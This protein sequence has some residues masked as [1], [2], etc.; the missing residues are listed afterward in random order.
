MANI[1]ITT[2]IYYTNDVP[3]IGHAYTT[4]A[5]DVLARFYRFR[6]DTVFFL[7]GSDEHGQ[8]IAR[9]AEEMG[10][11]PKEYVDSL[12]VVFKDLWEKLGISNDHFI[13]TTDEIHYA[14]CQAFFTK[15][16]AKGDIYKSRYAGLYCTGCESFKDE[17]ELVEGKCP[18]HNKAPEW[19]EEEDYF[20]KWSNYQQALEQ[21]FQDKPLFVLPKSRFNETVSFLG[22]GIKD[23]PISRTLISWGIPVP[24]DP[25]HVLY[26]WFDALINYLTGIGWNQPELSQR[27]QTF[28]EE[29]KVIHLMAKDILSKHA[30]LWPAML[31]SAGVPLP[32]TCFSHGYF[33][34]DGMKISKSIGNVID[35][36][37]LVESYGV[38][39]FRYFFFREFTFGEDG[40]YRE[41]RFE[42]RYNSDLAND[43]G[44]LVSR[45]T[46]MA[47][48]FLDGRVEQV[49]SQKFAPVIEALWKTWDEDLQNFRFKE[50]LE[51]IWKFITELNVCVDVEKPWALAKENK[52]DHLNEVLYTLIEGIRH[53]ALMISPFMPDASKTIYSALG[54]ETFPQ[55]ISMEE[56]V[57]G[58]LQQPFTIKVQGSLFPKKEK[59]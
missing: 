37:A 24:D 15:V 34:K 57:F 33:T 21:L 52:R 26:V 13:R 25:D 54:I 36:F 27:Y 59:T 8:K 3:H 14:T 49:E 16:L 1:Y 23:I 46:V 50:C 10:K 55:S 53:I 2:P 40:D 28:W 5:A 41:E 12:V 7:T 45:V 43:L 44:N 11:T 17:S 51:H 58:G 9:K 32:T 31:L 20:F 47:Q 6:G 19:M 35:P 22:Q 39:A 48:K 30:L 56:R 42:S 29:G 4:V 18:D 38:D